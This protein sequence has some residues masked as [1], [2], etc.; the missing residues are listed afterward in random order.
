[1]SIKTS[2]KKLAIA[3]AMVYYKLASSEGHI[4]ADGSTAL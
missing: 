3:P 4:V 1:M 2:E